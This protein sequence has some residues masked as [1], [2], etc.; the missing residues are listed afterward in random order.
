MYRYDEYVN[1]TNDPELP[2]EIRNKCVRIISLSDNL[3]DIIVVHRLK[4]YAIEEKHIKN[5]SK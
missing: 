3:E 2:E 4:L 1:L 5:I